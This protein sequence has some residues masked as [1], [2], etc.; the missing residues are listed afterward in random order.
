MVAF[1]NDD[2]YDPQ[3]FTWH[4]GDGATSHEPNPVHEYT[5]NGSHTVQLIA[6]NAFGSDTIT[7]P[8]PVVINRPVLPEII[9]APACV[10]ETVTFEVEDDERISWYG[11]E[12]ALLQ[13]GNT[14]TTDSLG[15]NRDY[16]V[17]KS[18]LSESFTG[19]PTL[20]GDTSS[21]HMFCG[22]IFDAYQDFTLQ[23]VKTYAQEERPRVVQLRD[24]LFNVLIADTV[25]MEEG[26]NRIELG[27]DIPK[28][29]KYK[30][31]AVDNHQLAYNITGAEYPYEVPEVLSIH[32]ST[33]IPDPQKYYYAFYDWEVTSY[34]C[35]SPM[36]TIK[37]EIAHPA[38]VSF[39][40][41]INDPH[42][43]LL[44]ST[45]NAEEFMWDFGDGNTTAEI[46]PSHT[47][48][49]NGDY[50]IVLTAEN[51]CGPVSAEKEIQINTVGLP[52][53]EIDAFKIFPNPAH[54][55]ITILWEFQEMLP[56]LIEL[57]DVSGRVVK[58]IHHVKENR[59]VIRT[60]GLPKG[61][62]FIKIKTTNQ[63]FSKKM[64]LID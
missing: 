4:F 35:H 16:L 49:E 5:E 29:E 32:G 7:L 37:A 59:T 41:E 43:E 24:S 58:T 9:T 23:S 64:V 3:E 1:S 51:I 13:Y 34:T 10:D 47:F 57:R 30:L 42:I 26:E 38:E 53:H 54:D 2:Y 52:G 46:A 31:V 28:G 19:K 17:R 45:E 39:D 50:T 44:N 61:I 33:F 60:E 18:S 12:G 62:Y 11:A 15:E 20:N 40:V 63:T 25:M 36:K 48:L 8:D 55:K 56:E 27:W 22:L 6:T 21:Y 14:Y